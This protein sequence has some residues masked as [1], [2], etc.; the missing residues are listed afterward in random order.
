M[1]IK[2][3]HQVLAN[4]EHPISLK[5]LE[6]LRVAIDGHGWLHRCGQSALKRHGPDTTTEAD[7]L[8]HAESFFCK[9]DT[10]NDRP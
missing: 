10:K 2:G 1:G 4:I 7:V 6:N 3:L 8:R 9:G 5:W